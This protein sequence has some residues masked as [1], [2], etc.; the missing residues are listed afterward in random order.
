MIEY[1]GYVGV[2]EFDEKTN[3]FIGKVSNAHHLITFQ[4]KSLESTKQAFKDAICEYI[5]WCKKHNKL[6]KN[7]LS[8]V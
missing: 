8:A 7:H 4:G 1:K 5:E 2:F 3:L 6:S